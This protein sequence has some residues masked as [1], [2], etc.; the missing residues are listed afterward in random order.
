MLPPISNNQVDQWSQQY[1][2]T[3]LEIKQERL[4]W[5]WLIYWARKKGALVSL[6]HNGVPQPLETKQSLLKQQDHGSKHSPDDLLED[7]NDQL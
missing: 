3:P 5:S 7:E 4:A 2:I 1:I 6:E